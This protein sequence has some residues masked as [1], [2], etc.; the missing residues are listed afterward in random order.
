M[1][2]RIRGRPLVRGHG[3]DVVRVEARLDPLEVWQG[4]ARACNPTRC[5]VLRRFSVSR[6]LT[7]CLALYSSA[8]GH[9]ERPGGNAFELKP[10]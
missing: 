9:R 4:A 8:V 3:G 6:G 2:G 1:R 10:G 7:R 5:D